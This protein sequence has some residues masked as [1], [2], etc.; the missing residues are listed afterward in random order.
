MKVMKAIGFLS[1]LIMTAIL[2]QEAAAL[3]V[4]TYGSANGWAGYKTYTGDDFDVTVVF[5]VYDTVAYPDEFTWECDDAEMP[6]T[7]R[8]IYAYQVIASNDS[9]DVAAF[10]ILDAAGASLSETSMHSTCAQA[11]DAGV[12]ISPDP[13]VSAV[14]GIWEWTAAVGFVEAGESSW[15]L[16]FSSAYAPTAGTFAVKAP[17][18]SD[19]PVPPEVPEPGTIA[20]LGVAS[21]L[22]IARR[23]KKRQS[24]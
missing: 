18:E 15:F 4:S 11:D 5:N 7:D 14:Q 22:F 1:M 9:K 12:G 13:V 17:E 21:S 6:D 24:Q 8:Y 3:P 23:T 19:I 2:V 16:I 20:L 10:R